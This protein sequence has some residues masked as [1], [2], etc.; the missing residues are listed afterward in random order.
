MAIAKTQIFKYYQWCAEVAEE[1]EMKAPVKMV[2][3]IVTV[4]MLLTGVASYTTS[5]YNPGTSRSIFQAVRAQ[6]AA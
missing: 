3:L 5:A 1:T 6:R 4:M 2:L